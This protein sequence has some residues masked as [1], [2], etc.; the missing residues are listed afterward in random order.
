MTGIVEHL[1]ALPVWLGLLVVF[2]LPAL[3]SSAFVGFVFP[4]EIAVLLGGVAAGQGH[5]PLAAVLGA[6]IGGAAVGDAVGYLV[7]QRWGRRILDSTVGRLVRAE[8]LDRAADLLAR[9]GGPAVFIGRFTVA[10]RVL[11][12]GL[13]GMARMPYRTFALFNIAGAAA[14]ASAVALAGYLAGNNWHVVEHVISGVGI[15]LAVLI[16]AGLL[17]VHLARRRGLGRHRVRLHRPFIRRGL[18]SPRVQPRVRHRTPG[19]RARSSTG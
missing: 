13:A 18:R 15:G 10:L 11:V 16:V 6:A 14:W 3:E 1:L 4:G 17:G 2:A 7:G 19:R 8:H 5:L 9:R 12:P